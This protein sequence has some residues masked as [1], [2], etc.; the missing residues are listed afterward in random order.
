MLVLYR[1]LLTSPDLT[2]DQA[3]AWFES[4]KQDAMAAHQAAKDIMDLGPDTATTHDDLREAASI[5]KLA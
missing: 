3:Q 5:L 1:E 2:R 4:V